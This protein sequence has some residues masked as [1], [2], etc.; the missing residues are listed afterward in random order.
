MITNRLYLYAIIGVIL[1]FIYFKFF[2]QLFIIY[3]LIKLGFN[4]LKIFF[5]TIGCILIG[6]VLLIGIYKYFCKDKKNKNK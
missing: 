4:F 2:P 5:I 1:L 6:I 3:L